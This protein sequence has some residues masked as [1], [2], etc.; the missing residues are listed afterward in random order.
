M[1]AA[2]SG[3]SQFYLPMLYGMMEFL[4]NGKRWSLKSNLLIANKEH[5]DYA[6]GDKV[7]IINESLDQKANERHMF[8]LIY[9]YIQ[10]TPLGFN[11]VT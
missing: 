4:C 10:M 1:Q 7:L 9:K 3:N 11:V 5:Y 6:I 2:P 8:F